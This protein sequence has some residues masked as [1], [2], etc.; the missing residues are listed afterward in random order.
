[1]GFCPCTQLIV[2]LTAKP[3]EANREEPSEHLRF[4]GFRIQASGCR[5]CCAGF[6]VEGCGLTAHRAPRVYGQVAEV[7]QHE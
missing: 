7:F 3:G 4:W 6:R 5:I 1:M 2:V